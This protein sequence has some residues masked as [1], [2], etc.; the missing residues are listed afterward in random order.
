MSSAQVGAVL[1]QVRKLAD[2]RHDHEA[3]DHQLLERFAHDR[4]EDAFAALLRRHGPM[5]LSVCRSVLHDLHDAEDAFQAAFLL[6]AQK[7]GSIHRRETVSAWLYRVAYHLAVRA[8]AKAARRR[9]VEKRAV[10]MPSADPVLDMSLREVRGMLFE[11]LENLPEQYRAPLVLCGLEE[12]SREEAARLLGWSASAVKGKLERGR[13]LLRARLRRRGLELS[14]GLCAVALALNSAS[15]RVSATLADSTLRAAIKVAVGGGVA[16]TVSA[17]VAALVQGASKTMFHS[18]AKIATVLMVALS[19]AGTTFGV[20]WHRA[21]ADQPP[22]RQTQAD[23]P[24]DKGDRA[25][26]GVKPSPKGEGTNEV[27]GRVLDPD[28]KP[29]A[30]AKLYLARSIPDGPAPSEQA[31]SGPDGRFRFAIPRSA[32]EKSP[33]QVMTVAR[34]YGC[35]WVPVGPAKA[36]LTLR[37]VK[38]VPV[39]GR[40]LDPDGKPV[41]G[42]KVRVTGVSAPRGD[43]LGGYLEA[44]RKEDHGYAFAKSW[45]G[46]LPGQPAALTTGADGRFRLAGIGRE[47]VVRLHVEGP[48]IATADLEAMS[49]VAKTFEA[50]GRRLYGASFDYLAVASR[51]I[52]GVVRDKD[53]RKPL[54]GVSVGVA[55]EGRM[56][57]FSPRWLT[58]TDKEG[59]YELL[60]LAK[61]Q[62]Y[63]L[64]LKPPEGMLFFERWAGFRDTG[65]LA[66]LTA[67]IDMV[68]GLT[69][70]GKVTDKATGKPVAHA[71]VNYLPVYPN[72]HVNTKV[73]GAWSPQSEASTGADGSYAL[74]VLPGPGVL[75]V[76]SPKPDEYVPPV[77]TPRELKDVFKVP[78]PLGLATA[79]GDNAAGVPISVHLYNA[80]VLLNPDPKGKALVKDVALERPL[81]RKGRVVGPDGKPLTGVTVSGLSQ[82]FDAETL[83]GA[84]FT[85]RRINPRAPGGRPLNFYHKGKNLGFFLKELPAEKADPFTVQ[86]QPCGSVSGRIVDQDGEPVAEAR[87]RGGLGSPTSLSLEL[88]TDKQ[89]RFRVEGL[90]PGVEYW[91][92]RPKVV[93]T[94][95]VQF[96]VE[97]G[98]HKDLG[99]LKV[100]VK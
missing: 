9:V 24:G 99:D 6:L 84:E 47:R 59:R 54:P 94:L 85:V 30:G 72:P 38:D 10:T 87:C 33:P 36:E 7:A 46:P 73:A 100:D 8:Q 41:A 62:D 22:P 88:T 28:G 34:G 32:L 96:K 43:D 86:L 48:A 23:K 60:G 77:V 25:L 98:K 42:A 15:S 4:D 67:D 18:K 16:G 81:E 39:R 74:T 12:K 70:R 27:R 63:L 83:K 97:A 95:L 93:A 79:I 29:V 5:V 82:L 53:T 75:G 13:E 92:M 37:L 56:L 65:G 52:R 71:R 44:I 19:V 68:R 89:G 3:P 11:E 31:T 58:V 80:L 2:A 61:A 51:P 1:R 55:G 57:F 21:A 49:R 40:V 91:I 66:P 50:A 78:L 45:T 35:D 64:A 26:P 76:T 17:E 69:V 90:V 14:S 20:V